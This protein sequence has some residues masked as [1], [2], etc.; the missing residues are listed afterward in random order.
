M[1]KIESNADII[2]IKQ[3]DQLIF[4]SKN[5]LR[6]N[7]VVRIATSSIIAIKKLQQTE[8]NVLHSELLLFPNWWL[9]V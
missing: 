7:R 4:R 2:R 3:R 9:K 6:E 5:N 8:L 1:K